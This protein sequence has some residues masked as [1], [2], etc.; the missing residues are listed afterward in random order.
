MKF[1]L[2]SPCSC[3]L[4]VTLLVVRLMSTWFLESELSTCFDRE[5]NGKQTN[6]YN[7]YLYNIIMY[8]VLTHHILLH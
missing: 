4:I 2:M 3:D 1:L 6:R 7:A 8:N 5:Y